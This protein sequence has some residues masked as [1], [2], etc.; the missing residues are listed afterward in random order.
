MVSIE[1]IQREFTQRYKHTPAVRA[2]LAEDNLRAAH[3][4]LDD[5]LQ[6]TYR[7]YGEDP[8]SLVLDHTFAE[9]VEAFALQHIHSLNMQLE[10]LNT[11]FVRQYTE[12]M[13][14][15]LYHKKEFRSRIDDARKARRP[16]RMRRLYSNQVMDLPALGPLSKDLPAL[17]TVHHQTQPRFRPPPK[18]HW[19]QKNSANPINTLGRGT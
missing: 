6:A 2:F 4:R 18:A 11:A 1:N 17:T 14:A 15:H 8:P 3:R 13:A 7:A 5:R 12:P 9:E 16:E 19:R 10:E